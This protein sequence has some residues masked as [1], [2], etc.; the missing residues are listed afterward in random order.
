MPMH[1]PRSLQVPIDLPAL[2]I[3]GIAGAGI[4]RKVT[5]RPREGWDEPTNL[6]VMAVLPPGDR[7]SQTFRKVLAPIAALER[8]LIDT[9]NPEIAKA[10]SVFRIA[11]KRVDHLEA[12]MVKVESSERPA[13]HDD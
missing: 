13:L 2:L 5:V 4:A 12:R 11:Q 1:W 9:M 7:K 10:E 8:G 3:L 6:F